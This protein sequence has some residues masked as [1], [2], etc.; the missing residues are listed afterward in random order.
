LVKW[1]IWS[2]CF[3]MLSSLCSSR[4]CG[5]QKKP[6][7]LIDLPLVL[8]IFTTETQREV[9]QFARSWLKLGSM[10]K[11]FLLN[12]LWRRLILWIYIAL[13]VQCHVSDK[14]V[15][16]QW[17]NTKYKITMLRIDP[18]YHQHWNISVSG[19]RYSAQFRREWPYGG[20][21]L[22]LW[23]ALYPDNRP[24]RDLEVKECSSIS[25]K[26]A[27]RAMTLLTVEYRQYSMAG[28]F[29]EKEADEEDQSLQICVGSTSWEPRKR[30]GGQGFARSK[31]VFTL[32][33]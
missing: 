21:V 19:H 31:H 14:N 28:I 17:I 26:V 23:I 24:G 22:I 32:F 9:T 8:F 27:R 3:S 18:L 15:F 25:E 2:G 12:R 30:L 10:V 11:Y 20:D 1:L 4:M 5:S 33:C 29:L 7:F 13:T 6:W 16:N